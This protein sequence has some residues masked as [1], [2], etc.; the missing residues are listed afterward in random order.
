LTQRR[1]AYSLGNDVT[2]AALQVAGW[3]E[4][5]SSLHYIALKRMIT[6]TSP[7]AEHCEYSI[8]VTD[9]PGDVCLMPVIKDNLYPSV[10]SLYFPNI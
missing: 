3:T 7:L 5:P 1:I 8:Q 4:I 10:H 9:Q 6:D 2:L